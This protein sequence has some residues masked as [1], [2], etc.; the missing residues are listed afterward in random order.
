MRIKIVVS[1]LS[2]LACASLM[3]RELQGV[4]SAASSSGK[5]EA[6]DC[7]QSQVQTDLEINNVRARLLGG[8]DLWWDPVSQNAHYEVPRIPDGSDQVS[9]S[10]IFAGALWIGGI[11][12]LQQLKVAAQTYRQTGDDFWPGPLDDNGEVT[13]DVCL[14]FDRHFTV[15]GTEIAEHIALWEASDGT[16]IPQ[17]SIPDNILY[18][19]ARNNFHFPSSPNGFALPANKDLAPYWDQDANGIYEPTKGDYPVINTDVEGVYADQMIWWVFNDKGNTHTETGGEAIGLEVNALAFAFATNDERNNMTFYKYIIDNKSVAPLDSVYFGQWVDAD[20]GQ[21]DNDWVGCVPEEGLGLAFNGTA[22]DGEYGENPPMIGV[23]FFRG[24][25]EFVGTDDDNNPIF[26]ELG[27]SAFVFYNNDFSVTGNPENASHFYGYLAGHWKDGQPLTCGGNG[28]G[29]TEPCPYMFPDDPTDPLGWSE[30]TENITPAD[31][32]FLQSSGAFRLDAGAINDVIVGVIWVRDGLEGHPCVSYDG[33]VLRA[34]KKA[35]ALFDNNFKLLDG[36]DAPDLVIRELDKELVIAF[37]NGLA[38][39]NFNEAYEEADPV[40]AKQGVADSSYRFQGYRLYQLT[41]PAVSSSDFDDPSQA[42]EVATVD[43]KDGVGKIINMEH[44]QEVD[45]ENAVLKVDA[46][47]EGIRHTFQ[48]LN[49]LFATG[50]RRLINNKK[51]YF[52]VVAYAYNGYEEQKIR[53]YEGRGNIKIYTAIPHIPTPQQNGIILNSAYNDAP[54]IEVISGTGNG[55]NILELSDETVADILENGEADRLIYAAGSGPIDVQIF[56]PFKVPKAEF[57]LKIENLI[58]TSLTQPEHGTVSIND[59]GET[60][61]YTPDD[62][63]TGHDGFLYEI[64]DAECHQD[65]G[66]IVLEIGTSPVI[67]DVLLFDDTYSLLKRTPSNTISSVA[68]S[69]FD[70]DYFPTGFTPELGEV[71]EPKNGELQ[72]IDVIAGTFSYMPNEGFEGMDKLSYVVYS[73]DSIYSADVYINVYAEV[74][75]YQFE[76]IEAVDDV[77]SVDADASSVLEVL[78]NDDGD[79]L[80]GNAITPFSTWTLTN[81]TTGEV[82]ESERNIKRGNQQGIGGWENESL[83]FSINVKQTSNPASN[84]DAVLSSNIIFDNPQETWLLGIPNQDG[85]GFSG[86]FNWIRSGTFYDEDD[87]YYNDH[88]YGNI[89]P[90]DFEIEK[91]YD[92]NQYYEGILG[93]VFSPYCLVNTANVS[94]LTATNYSI[95]PGCTDCSSNSRPTMT[96]Q[97]LQGID[98]VFSPNPEDWTRCVVIETGRS[99]NNTQGRANKN[100]MRQHPSWDKN[101]SDGS[102][103]YA[104]PVTSLIEAESYFVEGT[105]AGSISYTNIVGNTIEVEA[106]KFF[107]ANNVTDG[108]TFTVSNGALVYRATDIG[109]SYFPG[110]AINV[111]TGQRLN[112]MFGE[113]SFF[114]SDNGADMLWNP[115]STITTPAGGVSFNNNRIGGEH[116]IYIMSSAY[117][118]GAYYQERFV[119]SAITGNTAAKRAV[120]DEAMWTGIPLLSPAF[121]LKSLEDNLIPSKVTIKIRVQRAYEKEGEGNEPLVY[122]FTFDDEVAQTDQTDN[123][124]DALDLVRVVPNPYYAFSSYENSQLDNRV[125]ITNLPSRAIISIFTLDGTLIRTLEVD[126]GSVDTAKG[127]KSGSENIN[128]VDWDLTNFKNI[129]IAGG[130]Y[131]IHVNAPDLGEERTIKWFGVTRPVDLDTF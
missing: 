48:I 97:N 100:S 31:R 112:I 30:C 24:P 4:S 102:P 120:Y 115:T 11:D 33:A 38:S 84:V 71:G 122:R 92:P 113:N 105:T 128:S 27:M 8:G 107:R 69:V 43:I 63:F 70:N 116:F 68:V 131:L 42:R 91:Y 56:D 28:R 74:P 47:D 65:I 73:A 67:D 51:Y 13:Q 49:D 109:L 12:E 58:F 5:A 90:D 111:E 21:F 20:I 22:V 7:F 98:L 103:D 52:A 2:F 94:S 106:N 25:K 110:Y 53:Y 26:Q 64:S 89:D 29:G 59:D 44:V 14:N 40:L 75:L 39:N 72:N 85:N 80:N 108:T 81:L 86:V 117:D 76:H 57:E 62:G 35:Q 10:A 127:A 88:N 99:T 18:W 114:G 23:D 125:R 61:T 55:G 17:G 79:F 34:D 41:G 19:P 36:P 96:L 6:G 93:S 16:T 3:G 129:P 15:Y 126:N 78:D 95:S 123:A 130:M 50:D 46:P 101:V 87:S 82:Y 9:V 83:G 32:R 124:K 54:E 1:I 121:E 118:E 37:S 66:S 119:Q 60:L 45:Q 77:I 104:E